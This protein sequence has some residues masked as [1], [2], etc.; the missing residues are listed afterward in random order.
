VGGNGSRVAGANLRTTHSTGRSSDLNGTRPPAMLKRAM[1]SVSRWARLGS[2]HRSR[3]ASARACH[4]GQWAPSGRRIY[5]ALGLASC[6]RSRSCSGGAQIGS[7]RFCSGRS[8]RGEPPTLAGDMVAER[9]GDCGSRGDSLPEWAPIA[10]VLVASALR[11]MR[12]VGELRSRRSR[13]LSRRDGSR[14]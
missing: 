8:Q 11:S 14:G 10:A 7:D 13:P 12:P 4:V 6:R 3:L 9:S 5:V 1:F 2:H